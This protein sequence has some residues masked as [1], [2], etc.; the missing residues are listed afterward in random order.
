MKNGKNAGRS[1]RVR[2]KN[3][4]LRQHRRSMLMISMVLV[5]LCGVLTVN[6]ITIQ[7]KNESYKAQEAELEAQIR[8]EEER[9]KEVKEYEEYVKTDE[10]IKETAEDKLNLVDPN[11]IIFKSAE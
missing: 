10:Y 8:E 11:E 3:S 7:A 4:R 1:R 6:S 5:L 9:A 2:K